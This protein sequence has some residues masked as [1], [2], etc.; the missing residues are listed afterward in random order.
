MSKHLINEYH[1]KWAEENI[2]A[3]EGR[4]DGRAMAILHDAREQRDR[5]I[6]ERDA[7]KNEADSMRAFVREALR[8]TEYGEI[9]RAFWKARCEY[10]QA[11]G[12]NMP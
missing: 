11:V 3:L 4:L 12:D 9:D 2:T 8:M 5:A 1:R 6:K 10:I 7:A